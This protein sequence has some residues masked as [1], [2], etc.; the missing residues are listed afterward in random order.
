M[1]PA[2]FLHSLLLSFLP[3]FFAVG[4][5]DFVPIYIDQTDGMDAAERGLHLR[6]AIVAAGLILATF[7]FLGKGVLLVMGV[8]VGDFM[9]A[10]GLLLL[11]L[12]IRALTVEDGAAQPRSLRGPMGIVPLATPLIAGPAAMATT[13]ILLDRYGSAVTLASIVLNV[14]AAW[15]ILD[16]AVLLRR[17]LGD[18]LI[19]AIAKVSYILLASIAV[20][21]VRRGMQVV[22]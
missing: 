7:L 12:S 14:L 20:M 15:I 16:R 6:D 8:T 18:R 9:V 10:G 22:P 2:A 17:L 4:A 3:L 13:L 5:F 11:V 19:Q 1:D 21:M